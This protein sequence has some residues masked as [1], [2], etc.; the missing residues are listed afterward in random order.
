MP[1]DFPQR[2]IAEQGMAASHFTRDELLAGAADNA[3]PTNEQSTTPEPRGIW[4]RIIR[5]VRTRFTTAAQREVE[6][7][8]S[9]GYD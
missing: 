4:Q 6:R 1:T 8:K 9:L 7:R 2:Q 3:A 5:F